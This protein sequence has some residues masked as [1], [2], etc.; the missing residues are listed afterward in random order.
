MADKITMRD[1]GTL[2]VPDN[3]IIPFIEGDGIGTQLAVTLNCLLTVA[4]LTHHFPASAGRRVFDNLPDDQGIVGNKQRS[5][6]RLDLLVRQPLLSGSLPL[7]LQN[8]C[9]LAGV[10]DGHFPAGAVEDDATAS[11]P[12]DLDCGCFD[13]SRFQCPRHRLGIRVADPQRSGAAKH[14]APSAELC[15]QA[16]IW[17]TPLHELFEHLRHGCI[18]KLARRVASAGRLR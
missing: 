17:C 12:T 1:D 2:A 16:V 10:L 18:G 3:P 9:R 11:G 14:I 4:G 15:R 13:P 6:H 7:L 8:V 5:C